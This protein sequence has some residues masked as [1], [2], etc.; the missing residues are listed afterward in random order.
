VSILEAGALS[1]NE[2]AILDLI[3]EHLENIMLTEDVI[4]NSVGHNMLHRVVGHYMQ[5]NLGLASS[6]CHKLGSKKQK[7][8]VRSE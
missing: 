4:R 3:F 7:Y 2:I 8:Y 1:R 6:F 5:D